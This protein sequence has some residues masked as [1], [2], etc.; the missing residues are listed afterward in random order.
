MKERCRLTSAAAVSA[1]MGRKAHVEAPN[2]MWSLA[3]STDTYYQLSHDLCCS[4][5]RCLTSM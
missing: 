4:C 1:H 2:K 5:N 3:E